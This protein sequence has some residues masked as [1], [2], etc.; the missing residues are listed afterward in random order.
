M[1]TPLRTVPELDLFNVEMRVLGWPID[2]SH[3]ENFSKF[4]ATSTQTK[5]GPFFRVIHC[6]HPKKKIPAF[7]SRKEEELLSSSLVLSEKSGVSKISVNL[8]V[9]EPPFIDCSEKKF[10]ATSRL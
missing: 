9:S 6:L 3:F 7:P 8:R 5:V 10:G 4:E 2:R 1:F